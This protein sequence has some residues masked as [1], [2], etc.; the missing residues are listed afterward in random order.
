MGSKGPE[1]SLKGGQRRAS[2][3][4]EKSCLDQLE[5]Q[6]GESPA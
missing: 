1:Q 5:G 6:V 2:P 4:T 3:G